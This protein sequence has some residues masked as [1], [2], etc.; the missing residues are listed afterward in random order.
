MKS[1]LSIIA[2][3]FM[4]FSASERTNLVLYIAG[5]MTYKFVLETMNAC[6]NGIVI[7]RLPESASPAVTWA[8]IQGVNLAAQ[9]I[10]SL[11]IGPLVK[12]YHS[13]MS[14]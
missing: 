7:N 12:R 9:C 8:N 6:M 2:S 14:H 10:G 1:F 13:G 11:L 4:D 3:P 5:I